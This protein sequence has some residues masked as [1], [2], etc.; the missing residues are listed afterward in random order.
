MI[1]YFRLESLI[2]DSPQV[3]L[4]KNPK[5]KKMFTKFTDF[6]V[7]IYIWTENVNEISWKKMVYSF[8]KST[9]KC[10]LNCA[11]YSVIIVYT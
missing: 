10:T 4:Y 11:H 9:K 6:F 5:K 3:V 7:N 2:Q 8:K 1:K